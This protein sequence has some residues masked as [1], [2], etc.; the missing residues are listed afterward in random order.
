MTNWNKPDLASSK[1]GVL[2]EI[3]EMTSDAIKLTHSSP[4]N[5]PTSALRYN[6]ATRVFEEWSGSSYSIVPI[7]DEIGTVKM[8][9]TNTAPTG[10]L[11]LQGGSIGN[12]SS[13]ATARA[14][15]DTEA[16]FTLLWNGLTN[17]EAPVSGGRGASAAA[18]FA[19]NKRL[20]LPDMRQR[21][22]LG[23]AASGTG[24]TLGGVGGTIDLQHQHDVPG[25]YHGFGTGSS[26]TVDI[27]HTH[28]SSA[29]S[30]TVGGGDGIH[31]HTG[32]TNANE[33]AHTH[34]II[35]YVGAD[36]AGQTNRLQAVRRETGA[37]AASNPL[38]SAGNH[39][40]G[41]TTNTTG[42]GH[43][44]GFSLTAAGQTLGATSKSVSGTIGLVTGGSNGNAAFPTAQN[45][46]LNPPFLALNFIIKY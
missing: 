23:K 42:S 22:P 12:A 11:F 29:V 1:T 4:S 39:V 36:V 5:L 41:F 17:T 30:G 21:F 46:Q 31:T 10:Y 27:T 2:S 8:W 25:H 18:D 19:A 44:H 43:G 35:G 3:K 24:A 6:R 20:T 14:N 28:G 16:L 9:I 37:L 34:D 38:Q 13:A 26:A 45:A 40:H 15:A 32:A 33:G 7:A